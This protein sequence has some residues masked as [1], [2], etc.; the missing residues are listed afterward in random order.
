MKPQQAQAGEV[1]Y[2]SRDRGPFSFHSHKIILHLKTRSAPRG[3]AAK[4]IKKYFEKSSPE[5]QNPL[6]SAGAFD[7][8]FRFAPMPAAVY[9]DGHGMGG[10]RWFVPGA[11]QDLPWGRGG[12]TS[13]AGGS[14]ETLSMVM[15]RRAPA[16]STIRR[17]AVR[18]AE[19]A[20]EVVLRVHPLRSRSSAARMSSA[21]SSTSSA[22]PS[23]SARCMRAPLSCRGL[24]MSP[25]RVGLG[26]SFLR[27]FREEAGTI[28]PWARAV[29]MDDW[30]F[31]A[32]LDEL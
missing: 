20:Y 8:S 9:Y 21:I 19:A 24:C 23:A 15:A 25:C 5:G 16:P 26:C 3:I 27:V 32:C 7:I 4:R 30:F 10:A 22:P 31:R 12:S 6:D 14:S 17:D 28:H 13:A 29:R 11:D 1:A 18:A 2:I